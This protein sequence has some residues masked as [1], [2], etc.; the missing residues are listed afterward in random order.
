MP[1]RVRGNLIGV[2]E[3]F[4]RSSADWDQHSLDF[5][6]TLAGVSAVA[7]DYTIISAPR[8]RVAPPGHARAGRPDLSD[9]ELAIVRLIVEGLTNRE[10]SARVN[11]TENTIKAQVRRILEKTEAINRTDLAHR[12][13]MEG[14]LEPHG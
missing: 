2:L 9:L 8:S 12:A 5:F 13:A 14:W 4:K 6:E 11:R 1:L 7:I 10:I 3:M